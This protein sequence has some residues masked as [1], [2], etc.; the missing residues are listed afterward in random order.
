MEFIHAKIWISKNASLC[1]VF[2][3][4]VTYLL[5]NILTDALSLSLYTCKHC[6]FKQFDGLNLD[7]LVGKL[8]KRQFPPV[9]IL[10]YMVVEI[11]AS[12][13]QKTSIHVCVDPFTI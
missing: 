3:N 4:R 12:C 1:Q 5:E 7:G 10:R 13:F 9:K 6:F 2:A 8:Q 11:I